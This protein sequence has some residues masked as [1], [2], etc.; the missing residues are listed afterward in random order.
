MII[1][2][3]DKGSWVQSEDFVGHK[4]S[5]EVN[6]LASVA[7]G[8]AFNG[9]LASSLSTGSS[10]FSSVKFAAPAAALSVSRKGAQESMPYL[11]EIQEL[12]N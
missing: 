1:T 8:D 5:Y 7:A 3:S 10:L 6:V 9:A 12:M 11:H 2:L 4:K